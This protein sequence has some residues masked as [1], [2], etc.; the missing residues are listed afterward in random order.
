MLRAIVC[1]DKFRGSLRAAQAAAAIARGLERGGVTSIVQ[2]PLADGGEGSLDA[3]LDGLSG[4]RRVT[5][6]TGPSG[7]QIDAEWGMLPGGIAVIEMARASGHAVVNGA[8]DPLRA[9]SRGTG[10]LIAAAIRG[11][12]KHVIVGVGGSATTDGGLAA[13]DAL[14]WS[15]GATPVTVA[16][17]VTT[18]FLDAAR[19]YAP[20]KGASPAQ[21]ALLSRRLAV[22]ADTYRERLGVD[23]TVIDG[24]GAAGGLAGALAAIG[25]R[26]E[27]GFDVIANA[28]GFDDA[29]A[30]G[31][32]LFITGEGMLDASSLDGKVVGAALDGAA[33]VA[34]HRVVICGAADASTKAVLEAQ[35]VTVLTLTDRAWD[36][37]DAFTRAELLCEEA[38]YEVCTTLAR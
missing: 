35:G 21:V 14:K 12:C 10:E 23:V 34:T 19:V 18:R 5:A 20:Q 37:D 33:D 24:G 4:S 28:V 32:D 8:N 29:L 6:V 1:P 25:A 31:C 22:L 36:T 3:L 13:L 9:T 27:P 11:G 16:C 30:L 7:N 38:A 17:D 2:L 26:I 15:F